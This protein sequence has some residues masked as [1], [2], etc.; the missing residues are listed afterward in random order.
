MCL[1]ITEMLRCSWTNYTFL[2]S[3]VSSKSWLI[4][5]CWTSFAAYSLHL[6]SI[7]VL[8]AKEQSWTKMGKKPMEKARLWR[9]N[10]EPWKTWGKMLK[11]IAQMVCKSV[12]C[13]GSSTALS[14]P[15]CLFTQIKRKNWFLKFTHH[16]NFMLECLVQETMS[17]NFLRSNF[18]LTWRSLKIATI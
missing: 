12:Q 9:E 3:K 13:W 7:R 18:L 10:Q 6:Q 16:P 15:H 1:K 17:S 11:N 5:S 14:S 2:L 8:T 4:S